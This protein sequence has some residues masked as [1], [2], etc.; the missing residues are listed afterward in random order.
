M[1]N[2]QSPPAKTP[3]HLWAVGVISLLWNS[4]GCIDYT[5]SKLDPVGYM[6]SVG[7]G[8]AEIAYMGTL[9]AWLSVFWAIGVWGSLLGSILLLMRSEWAVTAFGVSLIGLAVSQVYQFTDSSMP[10][11]MHSGAMLGMTAVIWASL[12]FFLWYASRMKAAGV[13]R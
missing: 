2:L 10:A 13:L 11:S 4:F 5:M 7:M 8:E 3:A 1:D 12:L 6:Q 9:P